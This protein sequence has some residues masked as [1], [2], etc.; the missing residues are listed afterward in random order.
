MNTTELFFHMCDGR[1]SI[2]D[3][4]DLLVQCGH[5]HEDCMTALGAV[6]DDE[7]MDG[8]M[9]SNFEVVFFRA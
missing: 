5:S 8:R 6:L 9:N 1:N 3:I 2:N 7:T 4:V